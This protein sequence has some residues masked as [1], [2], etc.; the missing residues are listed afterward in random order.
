MGDDT[1]ADAPEQVSELMRSRETKT[2]GPFEW[3][4]KKIYGVYPRRACYNI[5]ELY[6]QCVLQTDCIR[7]K[8]DFEAC[9]REPE[10]MAERR[11]LSQ[12]RMMSISPAMRMRGNRWDQRSEAEMK[13]L[14]KQEKIKQRKRE[15]GEDVDE[16]HELLTQMTNIKNSKEESRASDPPF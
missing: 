9:R 8:K 11:G 5:R 14:L 16:T 4:Y 10:C 13:E 6:I 3:V 15:L 2:R 1:N 7:E 12:C